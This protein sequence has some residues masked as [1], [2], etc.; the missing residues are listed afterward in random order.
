[1][2]GRGIAGQCR[3][4]G[5]LRRGLYDG[6]RDAVAVRFGRLGRRVGGSAQGEGLRDRPAARNARA[7][8][9]RHLSSNFSFLDFFFFF[10]E[11][12]LNT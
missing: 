6:R 4:F 5:R 9:G 7:E 1:M 3:Q 2:A 11:Y 12:F 10:F 8:R